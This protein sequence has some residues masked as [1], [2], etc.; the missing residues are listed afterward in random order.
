[1]ETITTPGGVELA[2]DRTVGG[3]A[4]TV[5]LIGGAFSYRA[6]PK[7]IELARKLS[8]EYGLTVVNYDRR[9]RGDSTDSPGVYDVENEIDDLAALIEAV[10]GEAAVFGWSS[11]AGLA[12]LAA[13]SGRVPGITKVVAFEP[14]FVTDHENFVPPADLAVKL[15]ELIAA[16][17]RAEVVRYFMTKGMG[18]PRLF[19]AI[20]RF[21]P[22]WKSLLATA[23]STAHDWAIMGPY[24]RGAALSPA[25][26]AGVKVP[27]LV[28]SGGKSGALLRSA[29][30]AITAVL[31]N[32]R[33]EE[34]AKLSHNPN[35]DLL[36][37]VSGEFLVGAERFAA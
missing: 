18:T 2:F 24:M 21:T 26:W 20:M 15:H 29:A 30:R 13:A 37:P 10:G 33:H 12:L 9:G 4:G 23:P 25:D 34:V 27:T 8:K 35:I 11:G 1:M 7:M 5:I 31:P 19:A 28:V 16:D 17:R 32:A 3:E 14:P 6:F 22:F 36:V